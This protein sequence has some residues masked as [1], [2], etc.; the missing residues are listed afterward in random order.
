MRGTITS[1][2]YPGPPSHSERKHNKLKEKRITM[3]KTHAIE[4]TDDILLQEHSY[5]L[6]VM[7][8]GSIPATFRKIER[9]IRKL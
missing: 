2:I 4:I 5:E 8:E 3:R 9:Q 1:T 7:V 6:P